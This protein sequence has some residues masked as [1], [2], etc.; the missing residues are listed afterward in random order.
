[1]KK[2]IALVIILI[3]ASYCISTPHPGALVTYT[4]Q[5]VLDKQR[6]SLLGTGKVEKMGESCSYSSWILMT[7]FYFGGGASIQDATKEAGISRI[8]VVDR[9]SLAILGPVFYREC[10]QV[11]GE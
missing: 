3:S 5:H 4:S 2:L 9:S 10:V 7:F 8:A 11:W 6:G 1:M